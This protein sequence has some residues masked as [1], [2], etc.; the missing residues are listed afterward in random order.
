M[1]FAAVLFLVGIGT[2]FKLRSIRYGLVVVC[3]LLL[4]GA[5]GL[6]IA[7]PVPP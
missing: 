7:Q 2:T 4:V 6:L 3:G 1:L 5:V